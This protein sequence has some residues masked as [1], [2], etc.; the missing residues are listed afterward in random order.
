MS[1]SAAA[2]TQLDLFPVDWIGE[3]VVIEDDDDDGTATGTYT[4]SVIGKTCDGKSACVHVS[5]YPYFYV[6][7]PPGM[8][9]TDG[10]TWLASA[11]RKYGAMKS[12]SRIVTNKDWKT[13]WG[14]TNGARLN[15]A[16]LVF[17]SKA[18][19][20]KAGFRAEFDG[21]QTY[22]R[23]IDFVVRLFQLRNI[24]PARWL[25]VQ[26]FSVV[27]E[28]ETRTTCDIEVSC[29]FTDLFPS[30]VT[31]RPP[32]VLASWDIECYS[33]DGKFPLPSNP[34]DCIIQIATTFQR[35]DQPAECA[36]RTVVALGTVAEV[37]GVHV[38]SVDSESE[39]INQWVDMLR[40][41]SADILIGYNT[42]QFDWKYVHGRA[43][44]CVD[45]ATGRGLVRL[46]RLGRVPGKGG[47]LHNW[48]LNSNGYGQNEFSVLTTPGVMQIDL[49][50][51]VRREHKLASYSLNNVSLHFL[52]DKKIDLPAAEI[53]AKFRGTAEDRALIASYAAKDTDLPLRLVAKLSVLENLL[54]MANAGGS[55]W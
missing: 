24:A 34:E 44:V 55:G 32:L 3:D 33:A 18:A 48:E 10:A 53:F 25:R 26:Q 1:A 23:G 46:G 27:D 7:L 29:E 31:S 47:V 43:T 19:F 21:Y 37:P 12:K 51:Y 15:V 14:F 16:Q 41:E 13:V 22:E 42:H 35:Y 8:G 39:V 52:K 28:D 54:E 11:C 5:F 50:Q 40:R 36:R 45:D 9:P 38:V 49:L 2:K 20:R 4:V 17:D 6:E 30:P